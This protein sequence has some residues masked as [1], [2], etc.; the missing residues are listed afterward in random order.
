VADRSLV[1]LS[2][3]KLQIASD[4]DRC[5]HPQQKSGCCLGTP[6]EEGERMLGRYRIVNTLS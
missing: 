4:S 3:E 1:Q 5:R 2:S 6:I